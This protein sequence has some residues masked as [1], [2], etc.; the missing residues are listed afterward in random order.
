GGFTHGTG[1]R[2]ETFGALLVGQYDDD[3][4]LVYSGHVGTGYDAA[5]LKML[6][7]KLRPL[8]TK[9]CPFLKRP[10]VNN[11]AT[12]VKPEVTAAIKFA[13][14]T[15]DGILRA[16][17]FLG[18]REDKPTGEV[19]PARIVPVS[20]AR[21]RNETVNNDSKDDGT[22]NIEAVLTQFE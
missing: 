2:T 15:N 10:P 12:W 13:H 1:R 7:E 4:R 20:E 14:W 19:T 5:T 18:L 22:S 6:L 8:E 3:G 16:P 21:E 17:V 9:S 11:P